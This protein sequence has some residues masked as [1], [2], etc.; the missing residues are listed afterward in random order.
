MKT[1]YDEGCGLPCQHL[2][3]M[4]MVGLDI[5]GGIG[6]RIGKDK[7]NFHHGLLL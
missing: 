5:S 4:T 7:H 3:A 1:N 2:I 6:G